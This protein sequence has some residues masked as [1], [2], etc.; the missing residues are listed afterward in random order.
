M[1]QFSLN[2]CGLY[3][4]ILL[5]DESEQTHFYSSAQWIANDKLSQKWHCDVINVIEK[6]IWRKEMFFLPGRQCSYWVGKETCIR[7]EKYSKLLS[8]FWGENCDFTTWNRIQG[9]KITWT[10]RS[11]E[12]VVWGMTECVCACIPICVASRG[13]KLKDSYINGWGEKSFS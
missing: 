5:A 1:S 11:S 13:G 4:T 12:R 2:Q 6:H 3:V 9:L 8:G 10:W 7:R